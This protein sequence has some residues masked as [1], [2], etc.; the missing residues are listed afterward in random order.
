[1]VKQIDVVDYLPTI[2]SQLRSGILLNTRSGD[3]VNTMTISWGQIGIKWNK[4]FFTAFIRHGRFT[5]QL[6]E[7]SKEFTVSVPLN[8]ESR[9][10]VARAI[11]YCGANSG[12]DGNKFENMEYE[13]FSLTPVDGISVGSPAIKELPL[14]IECKVTYRQEQDVSQ[15]PREILEDCYPEGIPSD[16]PMANCDFHTLY[17]GEIVNAYII[18]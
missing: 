16:N 9:K 5:H 2:M 18:E 10:L 11:G 13:D 3:K 12:R 6:I 15:I 1:M 7:E 8:S 4:M 17:Y 14:T